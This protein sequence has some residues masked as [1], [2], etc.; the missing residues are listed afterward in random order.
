MKSYTRHYIWQRI[1]AIILL[2]LV[3]W[4]LWILFKTKAMNSFEVIQIINKPINSL[5]IFSML[6]SS[7]YHG[8]LGVNTICLDYLPNAKVRFL[9]LFFVGGLFIF[10]SLLTTFS[11]FKL[12]FA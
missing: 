8:Y 1:T 3:P 9:V 5:L 2:F 7:F 12:G 10:L 11:L 6:V 4:F